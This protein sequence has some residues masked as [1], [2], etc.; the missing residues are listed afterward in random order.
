MGSFVAVMDHPAS[1]RMGVV[2]ALPHRHRERVLDELGGHR[3]R[4]RPAE[5]ALGEHVDD[6]GGVAPAGPGRH[7]GHVG[8]PQLIRDRGGE[9]PGDQ[10]RRRC[11]GV[12]SAGGGLHPTPTQPVQAF[13][14][15]QP[16]DLAI[17][18]AKPFRRS[19]CVIFRR[20]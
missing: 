1:D 20:P 4:D 6:K 13:L 14:A 3:R 5:D 2:V 10:V 17:R 7:V 8:N 11:V 9:V 15:H 18:H 12:V 16:I 19:Q